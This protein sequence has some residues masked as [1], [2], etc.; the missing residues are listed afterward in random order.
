LLLAIGSDGILTQ[1]DV[2][3]RAVG[4]GDGRAE[5]ADAFER[6]AGGGVEGGAAQA[7]AA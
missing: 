5:D 7:R 2:L 4:V 1:L 6:V 3:A